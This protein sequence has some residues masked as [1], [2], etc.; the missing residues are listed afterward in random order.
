MITRDGSV[1]TTPRPRGAQPQERTAR[2]LFERH[3]NLRPLRQR[4][5]ALVHCIFHADRTAS[6]S[7]DLERGLFHCFGCGVHGGVRRFAELVGEIPLRSTAAPRVTTYETLRA[8]VRDTALRQKWA[9]PGILELYELGDHL[10]YWRRFITDTRRAATETSV[11]R[12]RLALAARVELEAIELEHYLDR[13]V[14]L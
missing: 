2:E 10:R 6:L 13:Y 7:V 14:C 4:S 12:P 1:P 9:E 8:L 3:L 11:D 5:R